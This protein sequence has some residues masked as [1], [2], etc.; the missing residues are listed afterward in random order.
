MNV[1]VMR[2]VAEMKLGV[3]RRLWRKLVDSGALKP[4]VRGYRRNRYFWA[5]DVARAT[6]APVGWHEGRGEV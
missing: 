5:D 1:L 4:G 3:N 6:G 2:R